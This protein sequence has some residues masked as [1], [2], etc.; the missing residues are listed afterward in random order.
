MQSTFTPS[1]AQLTFAPLF[2]ST[3][4]KSILFS[5]LSSAY[6]APPH[7]SSRFQRVPL[8]TTRTQATASRYHAPVHPKN[9]SWDTSWLLTTSRGL[10]VMYCN[11]DGLLSAHNQSKL[12]HLRDLVSRNSPL[13]INESKLNCLNQFLKL[14]LLFK[15]K[16]LIDLTET[17]T[18]E[19]TPFIE[20][21]CSVPA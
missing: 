2:A 13:D 7:S 5:T 21:L 1:N 9:I 10:S 12:D 11:N 15:D 19:A 17:A 6:W 14:K 4:V 20:K 8:V 3:A 16:L 18:E